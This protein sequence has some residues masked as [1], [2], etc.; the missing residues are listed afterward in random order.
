MAATTTPAPAVHTLPALGAHRGDTWKERQQ[1][2]REWAAWLL[3]R[4]T[5][6]WHVLRLLHHIH[7]AVTASPDP[8]HVNLQR[9]AAEL[10]RLA[11]RC[12]QIARR[13]EDG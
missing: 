12:E 8:G 3:E 11:D 2:R 5:Q 6:R 13:E 7:T 1:A 9:L 10:H 4:H